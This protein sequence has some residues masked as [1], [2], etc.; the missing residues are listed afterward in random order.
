MQV[1]HTTIIP[2]GLGNLH[3]S[4]LEKT[5]PSVGMFSLYRI[6][7]FIQETHNLSEMELD[8]HL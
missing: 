8:K 4:S 1:Q 5:E 2:A 3:R 7:I 6:I